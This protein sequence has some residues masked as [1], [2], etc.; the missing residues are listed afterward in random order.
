LTSVLKF[1]T[2]G[3]TVFDGVSIGCSVMVVST[4]GFGV[5][6]I[7]LEFSALGSAVCDGVSL[8]CGVMLSVCPWFPPLGV[9]GTYA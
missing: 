3:P 2:L 6:E 4:L 1:S 5:F 8:G 9:V 7:F